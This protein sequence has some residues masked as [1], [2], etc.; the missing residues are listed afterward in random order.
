MGGLVWKVIGTGGPIAAGIV[1]NKVA[2][3]AWKAA[4][5]DDTIDPRDPRTPIGESMAFAAFAG[6]IVGTARVM[7][8]RKA[9][10]YYE[11]SA[12]HLPKAM[13]KGEKV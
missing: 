9:A 3:K 5:R 11:K 1:A 4:G 6:L 13:R 2:G 8:T 10:K 12:G 7:T